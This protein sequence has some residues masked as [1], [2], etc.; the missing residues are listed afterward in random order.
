MLL[1]R[2]YGF[3][4]ADIGPQHSTT[5][6]ISIGP[7]VYVCAVLVGSVFVSKRAEIRMVGEVE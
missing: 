7:P 2:V 5:S 3:P 6:S 4:T 1:G